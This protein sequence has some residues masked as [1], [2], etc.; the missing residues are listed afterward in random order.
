[1]PG[2]DFSKLD[3]APSSTKPEKNISAPKLKLSQQLLSRKRNSDE[4]TPSPIETKAILIDE[5]TKEQVQKKEFSSVSSSAPF[6]L[7]VIDSIVV[8]SSCPFP[9]KLCDFSPFPTD[10]FLPLLWRFDCN[11]VASLLDPSNASSR[12]QTS[13][14]IKPEVHNL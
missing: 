1:M 14:I 13:G 5:E 6:H 10:S 9:R 8:S 11:S 4:Q 2:I 3:H 7:S 12:T